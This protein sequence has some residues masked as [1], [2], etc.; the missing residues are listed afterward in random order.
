MFQLWFRQPGTIKLQ[1]IQIIHQHFVNQP[2]KV[3]RFCTFFIILLLIPKCN[4]IDSDWTPLSID[5]KK[6]VSL[7]PLYLLVEKNWC[8]SE[9]PN[10]ACWVVS[11]LHMYDKFPI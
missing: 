1:V 6:L 8:P 3:T 5:G 10:L 9:R 4:S 7:G 11:H 2:N